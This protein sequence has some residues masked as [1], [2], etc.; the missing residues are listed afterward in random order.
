MRSANSLMAFDWLR[1]RARRLLSISKRLED[2]TAR[3]AA[4]LLSESPAW[5]DM[6]TPLPPG[7]VDWPAAATAS[8][9]RVAKTDTIKRKHLH[10]E[11]R[12]LAQ[13]KPAS[14]S[15]R[16]KAFQQRHRQRYGNAIR[17]VNGPG[18]Q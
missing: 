7:T 12:S 2:A 15:C 11:L 8:T 6:G 3:N 4:A 1:A 9:A 18:S 17:S 13:C 16:G 5:A 10:A 14:P